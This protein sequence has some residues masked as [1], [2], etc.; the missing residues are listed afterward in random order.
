MMQAKLGHAASPET[1][2]TVADEQLTAAEAVI[3]E[4]ASAPRMAISMTASTLAIAWYDP[5]A[6]EVRALRQ[7]RAQHGFV[8]F[9]EFRYS[10]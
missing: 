1:P 10:P 6:S 2:L 5:A 9:L 3:V 4:E 8:N 7:A